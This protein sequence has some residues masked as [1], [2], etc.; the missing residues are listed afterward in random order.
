MV[1]PNMI[2]VFIRTAWMDK[3]KTDFIESRVSLTLNM[4]E[5]AKVKRELEASGWTHVSARYT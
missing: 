1:A 4:I 3:D 2:L 5:I